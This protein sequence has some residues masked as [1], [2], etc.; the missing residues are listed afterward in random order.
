MEFQA[1]GRSGGLPE[2]LKGLSNIIL[3]TL[4]ATGSLSAGMT[5]QTGKQEPTEAALHVSPGFVIGLHSRA[6]YK[7]DSI[8]IRVWLA[9]PVVVEFH[10]AQCCEL[11]DTQRFA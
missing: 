6:L 9:P 5:I 3:F 10:L 2:A 8:C 11:L 1:L 7:L 4:Q